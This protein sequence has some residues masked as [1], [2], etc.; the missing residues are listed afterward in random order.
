MHWSAASAAHVRLRG[1]KIV[2]LDDDGNGKYDD[3]ERDS[4]IVG[5]NPRDVSWA[6]TSPSAMSSTRFSCHTAGATVDIRKAAPKMD[7]GLVKMI[8]AYK[9]PQKSE[10]LKIDTVII[11][12]AESSFFVRRQKYPQR[13]GSR[14][15]L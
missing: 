10:D 7:L 1:E 2:L 12:S 13:E 5:G 11:K 14:R 9:L 8:D 6:N 3:V 15:S 4:V